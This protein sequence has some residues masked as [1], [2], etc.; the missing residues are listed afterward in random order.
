MDVGKLVEIQQIRR[1]LQTNE[2]LSAMFEIL[3]MICNMR[4]NDE[5][6]IVEDYL[7]NIKDTL[8]D[9]IHN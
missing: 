9:D 1:I 2:Q 6:K 7:D 5:K 8:E 3:C 4:L